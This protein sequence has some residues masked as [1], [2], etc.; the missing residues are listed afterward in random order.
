MN[1]TIIPYSEL[2]PNNFSR[3]KGPSNLFYLS[4]NKPT[5]Q[6]IRTIQ[7]KQSELN[8]TVKFNSEIPILTT[9]NDFSYLPVY[10]E[11]Y[12]ID[13][14]ENGR[15][16]VTWGTMDCVVI[17]AYHPQKGIYLTHSL[18]SN[19]LFRQIV[20]GSENKTLQKNT[21]KIV[22]KGKTIYESLPSWITE[23]G[24]KVYMYSKSPYTLI[25][26]ARQFRKFFKG[27][28]I[29]YNSNSWNG[30]Q[31]FIRGVRRL[32]PNQ[33]ENQNDRLVLNDRLSE[34]K[35]AIGITSSGFF[36]ILF[37]DYNAVPNYLKKYMEEAKYD[38]ECKTRRN[39]TG[40][41]L[42]LNDRRC[43]Y[44]LEA[45]LKAEAIPPESKSKKLKQNSFW[46]WTR[47]LRWR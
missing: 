28:I 25:N 26:R 21:R 4:E 30:K 10:Q 14:I 42:E 5:I 47:K 12:A 16:L 18:R 20:S 31:G 33:P 32:Q 19:S 43:V 6:A 17:G 8:Y 27:P 7:E 15:A 34:G 13:S 40:K 41:K 11:G 22:C 37:Q 35:I 36:G 9:P 23:R 44:E 2:T 38:I 39:I 3:I 1:N 46:T 29:C 45:P 24:T